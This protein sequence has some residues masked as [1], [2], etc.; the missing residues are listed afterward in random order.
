MAIQKYIMK[1]RKFANF[2]MSHLPASAHESIPE[3]SKR[4][5]HKT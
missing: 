5:R 1:N 3:I 4:L 2:F